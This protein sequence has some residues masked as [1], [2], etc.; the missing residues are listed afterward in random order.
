MKQIFKLYLA[1]LTVAFL[2][3]S[4]TE[5]TENVSF[6]CL[7]QLKNYTGEGAY[8]VVSILDENGKYDQ[9][10]YVQ[11]KD[12]EWYHE[13]FEWWQFY[14]KRRTDIDSISGATISGG[15]RAICILNIPAEKMNKGYT[16]R[17]ETAVEDKGYYAADVEFLLTSEN[18]KSKKEGSGF[19]RYI[20]FI[21]QL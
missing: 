5:F 15:E 10:L 21:P 7:I 8:L 17:F 14:G 2:L 3:F 4:F 1:L 18:L 13:I 16:I 9:T 12:K 6:K 11:G 19:I 20:R